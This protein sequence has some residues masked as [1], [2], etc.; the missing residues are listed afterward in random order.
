[1]WL[2]QPLLGYNAKHHNPKDFVKP[3]IS[4]VFAKTAEYHEQCL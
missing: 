2:Q 3:E 1:M 4:S